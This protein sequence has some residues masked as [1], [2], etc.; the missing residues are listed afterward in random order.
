MMAGAAMFG[1]LIGSIA[2]V[3]DTI[4]AA[5]VLFQTKMTEVVPAQHAKL[6]SAT[7]QP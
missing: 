3:V 7:S 2:A 1:F 5:G 6:L 4:N